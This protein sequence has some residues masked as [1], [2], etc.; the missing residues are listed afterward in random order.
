MNTV[1]LKER[2]A[3]DSVEDLVKAYNQFYR[4]KSWSSSG[5]T[6]SDVSLVFEKLTEWSSI[7]EAESIIPFRFVEQKNGLYRFPVG[8]RIWSLSR[9]QD[10]RYYAGDFFDCKVLGE[11]R[12]VRKQCKLSEESIRFFQTY[13]E[14]QSNIPIKI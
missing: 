5:K 10:E 13:K 6:I 4:L 7:E 1:D 2:P 9:H 12:L 14:V 8:Y 11:K 3:L